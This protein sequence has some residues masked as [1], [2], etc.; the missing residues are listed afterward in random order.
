MLF[1]DNQFLQSEASFLKN[2]HH[3]KGHGH[4]A[5][6]F[7][8]IAHQDGAELIFFQHAVTFPGELLKDTIAFL[9]VVRAYLLFTTIAKLLSNFSLLNPFVSFS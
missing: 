1:F 3:V 9:S 4:H 5:A 7:T 6:F 8:G 2:F